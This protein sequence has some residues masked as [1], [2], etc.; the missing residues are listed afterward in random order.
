MS[1]VIEAAVAEAWH[2]AERS[3]RDVHAQVTHYAE[4][5]PRVLAQWRLEPV[6]W[7]EG[8]VNPPPLEV[9]TDQ[10]ERAVLKVQ[11]PGEQNVAARV[12]GAAAGHGHVRM[13]RFSAPDGAL[14]TERLG[15]SLWTTSPGLAD[16]VRVVGPLLREAW[17]VPLDQGAAFAAKASGLAGI[18]RDLGPRYGTAAPQAL[19][20]AADY[21]EQ[22][23]T[24][25][26]AEVVC[27]GDPHAG[28]VLRRADGWALI[29]PD[30]FV[31]ERAYDLGVVLRDAC[32]EFASAEAQNPG[33]GVGLLRSGCHQLA[34]MS[35]VDAQRIWQWGFVERVT[36]G[37]YLHWFGYPEQGDSFLSTAE[38]IAA[39]DV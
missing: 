25:E 3:D 18:L 39:S 34:E 4:T 5:V 8:G 32:V 33:A 9:V 11:P 27:H 19:K 14:L 21:A 15:E 36:T 10:G 29:D 16:Q 28:N 30:G 12:L 1:S 2:R 22:L 24:G 35:G 6:G 38:I 26:G 7:F 17:T 20:L 37:L 13:L 23:A 31:G